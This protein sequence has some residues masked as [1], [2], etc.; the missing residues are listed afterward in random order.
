MREAPEAT[1]NQAFSGRS[2]IVSHPQLQNGI[3][4]E[5]MRDIRKTVPHRRHE[6]R[7]I[8]EE[9]H[10]AGARAA[11]HARL[12]P[13]TGRRH[14]DGITRDQAKRNPD[15]GATCA[16]AAGSGRTRTTCMGSATAARGLCGPGRRAGNAAHGPTDLAHPCHPACSALGAGLSPKIPSC[17]P[18]GLACSGTK[19][20]MA[21][22]FQPWQSPDPWQKRTAL[23]SANHPGRSRSFN[24]RAARRWRS[25]CLMEPRD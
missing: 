18:T 4:R 21:A 22:S 15:H 5:Y 12:S 19:P 10:R 6:A 11:C 17:Q 16:R 1:S 23:I 7:F 20:S 25:A 3:Y 9:R 14:M 2:V 8:V 24:A 13:S